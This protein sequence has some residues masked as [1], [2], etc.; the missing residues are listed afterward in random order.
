MIF[1]LR[2]GDD[3]QNAIKKVITHLENQRSWGDKKKVSKN[4]AICYIMKKFMEVQ[5]EKERLDSELRQ[6]NTRLD[7]IKTAQQ[8]IER[9]KKT[10]GNILNSL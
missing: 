1:S 5:E 4:D 9:Q 2:H 7:R 6:A 8:E 10:I 3:E